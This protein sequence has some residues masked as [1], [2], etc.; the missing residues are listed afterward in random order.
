MILLACLA[1]CIS[2]LDQMWL[3]RIPSSRLQGYLTSSHTLPRGE[4]RP[5]SRFNRNRQ[6][7]CDARTRKAIR[8]F[9]FKMIYTKSSVIVVSMVVCTAIPDP[10]P[11]CARDDKAEASKS[12]IDYVS[13]SYYEKE[14]RFTI[15]SAM[16]AGCP[17]WDP[18]RNPNPP[19]SAALALSKAGQFIGSIPPWEGSDWELRGLNLVKIPFSENWVWRVRYDLVHGGGSS[20]QW[21]KMS[22]W[23]LMDGTVVKPAILDRA[24]TPWVPQESP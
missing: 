14:Y 10:R 4:T 7:A 18:S 17:G 1:S 16:L 8:H 11:A 21:P 20:G 23:V 3:Y 13:S 9:D 6:R 24:V 5:I 2:D 15:T 22:C 19:V 12:T